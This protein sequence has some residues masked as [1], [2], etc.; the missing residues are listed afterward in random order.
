[1]SSAHAGPPLQQSATASSDERERGFNLYKQG[2][3]KGAIKVLSAVVNKNK[4]DADAWHYLGLAFNLDG[5]LKEA[6]KAFETA[7][8]LRPEFAAAHTGFA[9]LLFLTNKSDEAVREAERALALSAQ[10]EVAH[11]VLGAIGLRNNDAS[12]ALQEADAAL[13]AK[14]N[15]PPALLL[16]SQAL[17]ALYLRKIPDSRETIVT[18]TKEARA[19]RGRL[20]KESTENLEKY[21]QLEPNGAE[22]GVW[23]EQLATLRI[24]AGMDN[25]VGGEQVV[26]PSSA[27][28]VKARI[29]SRVEPQY[30]E[31][32]RRAGINGTV[33]LRAVLS[34]DGTVKHILVIRGLPYGL[35]QE[36]IQAARKIKFVPA[37]KDGQ[38]VSQF[39]QI[40]YG[41]F[42]Y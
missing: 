8:K 22:A 9:Y 30:T 7:T 13:Q 37:T 34:S 2:D 12:K 17:F 16:K 41:F 26:Y 6:R 40:E 18:D 4:T 24:Y 28:V 10:N 38:P 29:L 33:V 27:G 36:A 5:R 39:I 19:E 32:A 20:L 15:Y 21:L 23:R 11:Y 1:M 31:T 35:T 14:A 42:T 3:I 25:K